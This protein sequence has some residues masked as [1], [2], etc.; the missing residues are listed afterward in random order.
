[1]AIS[2]SLL[3]RIISPTSIAASSLVRPLPLMINNITSVVPVVPV[4]ATTKRLNM[5]VRQITSNNHAM[6][7]SSSTAPATSAAE[8]ATAPLVLYGMTEG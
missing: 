3:R 2:S 6:A 5:I 7:S 4:T 1:M 8:A